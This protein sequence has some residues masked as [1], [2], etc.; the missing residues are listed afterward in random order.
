MLPLFVC[1]FGTL[2]FFSE[3]TLFF[4]LLFLGS[5]YGVIFTTAEF[6]VFADNSFDCIND[7][8]VIND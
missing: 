5:L 8:V 2:D 1:L 6:C 4:F 7:T 3:R